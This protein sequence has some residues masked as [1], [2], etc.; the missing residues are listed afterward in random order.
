MPPVAVV[1]PIPNPGGLGGAPERARSS[2]CSEG[3]VE[4]L[5]ELLDTTPGRPW[6]G[7]EGFGEFEQ[8]AII[9]KGG[10]HRLEPGVVAGAKRGATASFAGRLRFPCSGVVLQFGDSLPDVLDYGRDLGAQ[11]RVQPLA[12]LVGREPALGAFQ[13]AEVADGKTGPCGYGSKRR[14]LPGGS[15]GLPDLESSRHKDEVA[16]LVLDPRGVPGGRSSSLRRL[17]DALYKGKCLQGRMLPI[18][19]CSGQSTP[20]RN[21]R[22]SRPPELLAQAADKDQVGHVASE[23]L[24]EGAADLGEGGEDRLDCL[25]HPREAA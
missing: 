20:A 19:G 22:P 25:F 6:E 11:G 14:S 1:A 15:E 7:D 2:G 21:E 10:D 18:R 4:A 9:G 5:N 16:D 17:E 23:F 24:N 12:D 8:R 13:F 3:V